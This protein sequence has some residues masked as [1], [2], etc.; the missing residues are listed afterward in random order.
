MTHVRKLVNGH[1]EIV[2]MN[3]TLL[4]DYTDDLTKWTLG[5]LVEL[6]KMNEALSAIVDRI[7]GANRVLADIEQKTALGEVA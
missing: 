5:D 4:Q 3:A 7:S 2:A 6:Q 1:L